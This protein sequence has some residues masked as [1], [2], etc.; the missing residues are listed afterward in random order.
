MTEPL[1]HPCSPRPTGG[2]AVPVY[3]KASSPEEI[4]AP[5][6][7]DGRF[8][9]EL[10]EPV[11]E[12]EVRA[13][14]AG[15][16]RQESLLVPAP[17]RFPA[18]VDLV[19]ERGAV[20]SGRVLTARGLPAP[21][22]EVRISGGRE[23]RGRVTGPD[24][25]GVAG[26]LIGAAFVPTLQSWNDGATSG[27]DGAFRLELRESDTAGKALT[28][29]VEKEGFTPR[30]LRLDPAAVTAA[31]A[32]DAAP[33]AVRLD[34]GS[35][36]TGHI[37]GVEAEKLPQ[38]TVEIL[39]GDDRHRSPVSRDGEFRI[40][41]LAP[42]ELIAT[43]AYEN[44]CG[45]VRTTLEPGAEEAVLDL[46]IPGVRAAQGTVLAPDGTPVAGASVVFHNLQE[47]P[48][49]AEKATAT[50]E[51]G[52]DGSFSTPLQEGRYTVLVHAE[53]YAPAL[54]ETPLTVAGSP[55]EGLEVRLGNPIPR[56]TPPPP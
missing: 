27:A 55:V 30:H 16:L 26:A 9:F 36:L 37:L 28:L 38:V 53:G 44:R 32:A 52:E 5:A 15:Y 40:A 42:E 41:G 25:A 45:S 18:T 11:E 17:P 1:W 48:P 13:E 43:A 14:A 19:L 7:R 20:V 4:V 34:P 49:C 2:E 23:I 47:A 46:E 31:V 50:A 21:R 33:L 3:D 51:S 8:A 24:G 10:V 22:A 54:R 35:R 6:G 29:D 39:Q 12:M 56:E